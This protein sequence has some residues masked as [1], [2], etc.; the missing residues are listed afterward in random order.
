MALFTERLLKY[1]WVVLA[2]TAV[3]VALSVV[4][5][6]FLV[7]GGKIN[8][9][10]TSYF[11]EDSATAEGLAF[12]KKYFGVKGDAFVVVEGRENDEE[13][14]NSVNS[15]LKKIDGVTQF[16]WYGDVAALDALEPFYGDKI[17]TD[18]L[19]SYLRRPNYDSAGTIAGY[20]YV[21]LVLFDFSPS[22]KEAFGVH[23]QIKA[24]LEGVLNRRT[25]VSGMTALA[26]KVMRDTV[27]EM[28]FYLLFCAAVIAVV[29]LL[30][31]GS[32][33]ASAVS[34]VT[35]GAALLL[36]LGTNYFFRDV[37]IVSF[38]A[39]GVLQLAITVTCAVSLFDS[40]REGKR[41]SDSVG[42]MRNALSRDAAGVSAGCLATAGGLAAMY[43]MRLKIGAD[44]A[45]VAIKGTVL[46]MASVLIFQPCLTVA[47]AGKARRREK[48]ELNVEPMVKRTLKARYVLVVLAVLLIVPAFF[49]QKNVNLDYLKIYEQKSEPTVRE[50]LA[51]ELQ[52]QILMA[53]PLETKTGSQKDF[54]AEL[55]KDEKINSVVGAFSAL[56]MTSDE[57][58]SLLPVIIGFKPVSALFRKVPT[59][60]GEKY[61]TLCLVGISGDVEGESA[62]RSY[63]RLV[64]TANKY[65]DENYR[66]GM[67]TGAAD[68]AEITPEDFL[69]I[70][71]AGAGI[72]SLILA[73]ALKSLL[74]S[75][76][77]VLLTELSIWVN[78]GI[79]AIFNVPLNFMVYIIINGVQTGCALFFAVLLFSRFGEKRK[80]GVSSPEAAAK[81]AVS[82]FP[83]I[84]TGAAVI[85]LSCLFIS[86]FSKNL[87]VKQMAAL[88]GRGTAIS[89]L[90]AI[91][92]LPCVLS[93][94]GR[95]GAKKY[96][97]TEEKNA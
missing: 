89:Y 96:K 60:K 59:E 48:F 91:F 37:S 47:F 45:G 1:R 24:E 85:V 75:A 66:F 39:G 27:K 46:G 30:A 82:V 21:M 52:N 90:S 3:S 87:L 88:T 70:T 13:L 56:N 86:L 81:A 74:G 69:R 36:N 61:F 55:K 26:D 54:I 4:G 6:V 43:F 64:A 9:D 44:L 50:K 95:T 57:V 97:K 63:G 19:K 15:V 14:Q 68:M 32:F 10:M 8:S 72:I 35:L 23:R 93:F 80:E 83:T 31:T 65:F 67:L 7:R 58:E 22:T 78:V 5:T 16:I 40:Y 79:N 92:F 11:P 41:T 25:V 29:P 53:V 42:A 84:T 18:G 38:A 49:G 12:L 73:V 77:I 34:A 62:F 17:D 33:A 28:P 2:L 76:A 51:E 71:L 20:N 94:F